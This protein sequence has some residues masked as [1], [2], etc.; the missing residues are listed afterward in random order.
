MKTITLFVIISTVF[1]L[2]S[3][4]QDPEPEPIYIWTEKV[5]ITAGKTLDLVK[6]I[7]GRPGG[8]FFALCDS[9]V[10]FQLNADTKASYVGFCRNSTAVVTAL[11]DFELTHRAIE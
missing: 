5:Q 1:C 11:V 2:A 10:S 9:S 6:F 8:G 3:L 4:A 7:E